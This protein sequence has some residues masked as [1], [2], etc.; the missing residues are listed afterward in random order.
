MTINGN[1]ERFQ[2]FDKDFLENEDLFQKI[3]VRFLDESTKIENASFSYKTVISE[4]IVKTNRMV[5][6]KWTY[7][8]KWSLVSNY[9]FLFQF[10]NLL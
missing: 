8:R 9:L 4:V 7:Y 1:F 2:Y 6:T 3:G 10:K 5:S